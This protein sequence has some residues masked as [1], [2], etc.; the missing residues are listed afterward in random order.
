MCSVLT[1]AGGSKQ[2][3]G[4]AE[5]VKI[6]GIYLPPEFLRLSDGPS[7]NI[8]DMTDVNGCAAD[9]FTKRAGALVYYIGR[10][11][12]ECKI[13]YPSRSSAATSSAAAAWG[14]PC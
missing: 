6:C 3:M 1:L 12:E 13:A 10:E 2:G 4:D 14:S 7:C 9:G 5:F 11:H 8:T